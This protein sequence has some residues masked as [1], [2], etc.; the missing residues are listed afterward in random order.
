M[1]EISPDNAA[2]YLREAG[3]LPA[4]RAVA[5]RAL[6]WGVSNVVLRVD[7]EGEP[8]LVLKQARERLRVKMHWVSRIDRIWTER[9]ALEL[10]G[11][12]LPEGAV[13]R[14]LFSDE[15]NYLFAMTCAP[16][17]SAVWKEQLLAGVADPA[18]ARRAGETLAAAHLETRGHAALGGRLAD[19]EVFDQLRIDP[20]YRTAARAHPDLAPALDALAASA[21]APPPEGRCLV[22]ADFSPKNVLVHTAGLTLVDFE[23][24]HAGDPAYDVGFFL[25]HLLL[26]ALHAERAGF[27]GGAGPFLGLVVAFR[28][29]YGRGVGPAVLTHGFDRRAAAH[30]AGCLL[31]R[32]DGK[33]PVDYLDEPARA[34]ARLVATDALA[35]PPAGFDDLFDRAAQVVRAIN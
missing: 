18:V 1:R 33:S 19:T 17:D 28:E 4:G 8:P 27:S 2:E 30:L 9:D 16:D 13:P 12:V 26:K 22:L 5:A 34:A 29:A 11:H 32:V 20:F 15:P 31:A 14:V 35:A 7:V 25:S 10:L 6:G 21:L 24:A 23:T 3:R